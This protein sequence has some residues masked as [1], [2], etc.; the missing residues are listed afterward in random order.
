MLFRSYGVDGI[1]NLVVNITLPVVLFGAFYNTRFGTSLIVITIVMM[2]CCTFGFLLGK[3]VMRILPIKS[4][5]LPFLTTGFEAGMMG[6]GLFAILLGEE[7]I[8]Y[9]AMVDL[10]QV[11][12]VFTI[13]MAMLNRKKDIS[14]KETLLSMR[15]SPVLIAIVVGL[16]FSVTGL[17]VRM[18]QS[19]FGGAIQTLVSSLSAPTGM[20]MLVAVGYGLDFR[21]ENMQVAV[22]AT[23]LRFLIMALLGGVVLL[24]L[25]TI[26]E[27]PHYLT[28]AFV[29]MFALPAPFVLPIFADD[30][31][32]SG[33]ISTALS[34]QS[35]VT[36][37]LFV[38]MAIFFG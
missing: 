10:G 28:L 1:K 16:F 21:K 12:F 20:L 17:G 8:H 3:I 9:F 19:A 18:D 7:N 6:Y 2:I 25:N 34:L 22:G 35:L 30:K 4:S 23:A 27:V 32:E 15:K 38:G 24:V 5:F 29:L 36:I 33:M 26:G 14:M 37:V 31:E 13:Y 11:L